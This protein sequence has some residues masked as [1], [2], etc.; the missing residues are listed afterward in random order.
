MAKSKKAEGNPEVKL[1]SIDELKPYDKNPRFNENAVDSVAKSIEQFGFRTPMLLDKNGVIIAGHTRLKAAKKLGL[2]QVPVIYC[3]DLT[4]TQAK[5]LRLVDNRTNEL[6]VW[7]PD[8]LKSEVI[9]IEE[10]GL[11]LDGFEM[12]S[13]IDS[14]SVDVGLNKMEVNTNAG[15]AEDVEFEESKGEDEDSPSHICPRCGFEW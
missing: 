15:D 9:E 3:D 10:A 5:A 2:K 1:V 7:V 6:A 13:L 14:F 4:E 12:D 8:I 11:D